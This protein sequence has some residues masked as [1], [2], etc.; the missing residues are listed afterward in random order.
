VRSPLVLTLT[1]EEAGRAEL[2]TAAAARALGV[3]ESSIAFIRPLK[4]SIDARGGKVRI[5]LEAEVVHGEPPPAP[6]RVEREYPNVRGKPHVVIIGS[7]PAGLFAAL[8]LM[9]L[10]VR[11][12]VLE[13]GKDVSAR[14]KDLVA[15]N[16]GHVVR[17]D[18]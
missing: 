15:L 12:V 6:A 14:R 7:G 1:P 9:E 8:R 16:R 2:L 13:R 11:P 17:Q 3:D 18:P 5:R 4:R 10:G